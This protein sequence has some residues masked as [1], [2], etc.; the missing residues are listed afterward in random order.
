MDI[1]RLVL[2]IGVCTCVLSCNG[3]APFGESALKLDK[4]IA[5]PQVRGRID[6]LDANVK[7]KVVY[8]AALGNNTLEVVDVQ[9]GKLLH[10]IKGLDEPQGVGYVAKTNEIFVANGGNGDCYFYNAATYEK[11]ASIH[12]SSDA[13]DVRYDPAEEKIYVGYGEGGIAVID[14]NTHKQIADIKLPAHP[15]GFQLDKALN[16]ILVN[17]PDRDMV[18]VID[19]R[20]LKL[21]EQWK[22]NSPKA[23]FPIA[24]DT[25]SH[26]AFIGYRHPAKL[27]LLDSKTGKEISSTDIAGDVDDLYFD[28]RTKRIYISGG[29]GFINIFQCDQDHSIRQTANIQSHKG[30]RTSLLIPELNLLVVAARATSGNSAEL[31]IFNTSQ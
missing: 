28:Q 17:I 8:V 26:F 29:D 9:N 3:Q 4:E 15:E 27:L 2:P 19:L 14:I 22:R 18:G 10:S 12:L 21:V 20:Q 13:D 25:S 1:R 7:E 31:L 16:R 5:L 23:N 24:V 11:T 30:A 6:H